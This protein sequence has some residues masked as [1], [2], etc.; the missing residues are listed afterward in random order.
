M[1]KSEKPKYPVKLR[2]ASDSDTN[3]VFST[4]LK[5]YRQSD[6]AKNMSNDVFFHHHKQ[7]I[8]QILDSDHTELTMI[9]NIEDENQIFGYVCAEVGNSKALIHFCYMKYNFRSMGI[10]RQ[11]IEELNLLGND[12]VNFI[13]HLP[14]NY[15][16]L[17]VKFNLE[18]DPYLLGD[19]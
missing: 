18:F 12:G 17:K 3:F 11:T 19:I 5:S 6:W 8:Q 2:K 9:V 1:Q 13:T 4:W 15:K 7:I 14:R 10:M 16:Q